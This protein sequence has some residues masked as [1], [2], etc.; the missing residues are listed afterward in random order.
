MTEAIN[1]SGDIAKLRREGCARQCAQIREIAD[2][3]AANGFTGLDEQANVLGVSRATAWN[4]RHYPHKNSGLSAGILI[5][6]LSQPQLPA[7]VRANVIEYIHAKAAGTY[8]HNAVQCRRFVAR[9]S[10]H[11]T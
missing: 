10:P 4:L 8:G 11:L 6:M 9:M 3:L 5:R 2:A 1:L 7:S